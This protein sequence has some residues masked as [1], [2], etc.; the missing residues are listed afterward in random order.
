MLQKQQVNF[1]M[2]VHDQIQKQAG[3]HLVC[4]DWLW[5]LYDS[6][7]GVKGSLQ[8]T[9]L[10]LLQGMCLRSKHYPSPVLPKGCSSHLSQSRGKWIIQRNIPAQLCSS[11][12]KKSTRELQPVWASSLWPNGL[13]ICSWIVLTFT[14]GG[15][16]PGRVEPASPMHDDVSWV[17]ST[18]RSP[19]PASLHL[20]AMQLKPSVSSLWAPEHPLFTHPPP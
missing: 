11:S 17:G 3:I 2:W 8:P 15:I 12:V 5:I 20:L 7:I 10:A 4:A 9:F 16:H 13:I 18:P 1:T 19:I 14:C 6:L